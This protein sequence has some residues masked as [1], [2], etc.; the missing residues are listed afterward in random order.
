MPYSG[1]ISTRLGIHKAVGA[2]QDTM[3]NFNAFV[4]ELDSLAAKRSHDHS[5]TDGQTAVARLR[6]GLAS[7]RPAVGASSVGDAWIASDTPRQSF[8]AAGA[9]YDLAQLVELTART[10]FVQ[11]TAP[12]SPVIWQTQ[13]WD[14]S[15]TPPRIKI[16]DGSVWQIIAGNMPF[17]RARRL[18]GNQVIP[19]AAVTPVNMSAADIDT[20]TMWSAATPSR[21]T[22]KYA[23]RWNVKGTLYWQPNVA[24]NQ[25][26]AWLLQNGV[27]ITQHTENSNG[28][29]SAMTQ[30]IGYIIEAAANDYV[31][32][33]A[34]Q[35]S[36]GDVN[37]GG[38]ATWYT[39]LEALYMGP[40]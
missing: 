10:P 5:N 8:F 29:A 40:G 21:V 17:V 31:Q 6:S 32:L 28:N 37:V 16:W 38:I 18:T 20:D 35:N 2:D 7:A 34:W 36:S 22:L 19:T 33:G 3:A 11:N 23:G 25:R 14:T 30:H 26:E 4:D 24:G 1:V 15:F 9:W 27:G 13:W 12:S 39:S